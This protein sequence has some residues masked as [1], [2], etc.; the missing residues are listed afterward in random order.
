[1]TAPDRE[2]ATCV[3]LRMQVQAALQDYFRQLDGELPRDLY[4]FVLQEVERPLLEAVMAITR[5]NQTRA[6]EVLGLNRS[7]LR[8]KLRHYGLE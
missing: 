6:A 3:P 1:M 8:K 2:P 5:G 4:Q 7:T